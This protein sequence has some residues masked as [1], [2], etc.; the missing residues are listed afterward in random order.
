VYF[1]RSREDGETW[2]S[3]QEGTFLLSLQEAFTVGQLMN[4]ARFS[5][6]LANEGG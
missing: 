4:A 5:E 1:F 3:E 6:T 2:V